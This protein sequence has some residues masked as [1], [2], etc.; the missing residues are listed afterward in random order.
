MPDLELAVKTQ[1]IGMELNIKR[2]QNDFIQ[3]LVKCEDQ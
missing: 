3:F 1:K 2:S